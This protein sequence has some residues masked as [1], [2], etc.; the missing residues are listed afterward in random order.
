V[1]GWDGGGAPTPPWTEGLERDR[2]RDFVCVI[3]EVDVLMSV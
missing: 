2:D 3:E 1:W